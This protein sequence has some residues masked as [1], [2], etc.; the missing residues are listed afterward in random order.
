MS[1]LE[2]RARGLSDSSEED[3]EA[4]REAGREGGREGRKQTVD[5]RGCVWGHP[6]TPLRIPPSPPS[7]PPVNPS[8]IQVELVQC[9]SSTST[10]SH[11][12]YLLLPAFA[13]GLLHGAAVCLV[14]GAVAFTASA[15]W[16][17]WLCV[18]G[19]G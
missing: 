3:R 19:G 14:A 2:G 12:T 1:D 9:S 11:H 17:V 6:A 13:I 7:F 4:G 10:S 15:W 8:I 18:A 16:C 5:A